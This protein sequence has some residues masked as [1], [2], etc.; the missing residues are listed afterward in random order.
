MENLKTTNHIKHLL[1]Y[2]IIFVCKYRKCL[3]NVKELDNEIKKLCVEGFKKYKADVKYLE[4]DKDHLHFCI[5][6]IPNVNLSQLVC[7]VKSYSTY[8]IWQ[9]YESILNKY[10][11]KER[12]FW[13][14]GTFISSIGNVSE[15]ILEKYIKE[16]S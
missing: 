10:F 14:N 8:H 6:T 11:W 16:Q 15:K 4:S 3:L 9:K 1:L 7:L 12:T 5:E 2:H 13:T